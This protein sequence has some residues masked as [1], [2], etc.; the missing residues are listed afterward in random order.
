MDT[1]N[2][3][4]RNTDAKQRLLEAGMILFADNGF[5]G[6]S[7]RDLCKLANVNVSSIPY[8]FESKKG[9]YNA[10]LKQLANTFKK[11]MQGFL[12]KVNTNKPITP[13][14]AKELILIYINHHVELIMGPQLKGNT[15]LL[16][17]R[18]NLNPSA[19]YEILYDTILNDLYS[20]LCNLIGIIK[21]L[22]TSNE[23]VVFCSNTILGQVLSFKIT[24]LISLRQLNIEEYNQSHIENIKNLVKK[25]TLMILNESGVEK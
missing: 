12:E 5:N 13:Q 24:T 7:T 23:E 16:I 25:Q 15:P 17:I 9:L 21:G 14:E 4:K 6:T 2:E 22:E 8:Y 10:V 11:N 1:K 18:E 20:C 19:G 3:I